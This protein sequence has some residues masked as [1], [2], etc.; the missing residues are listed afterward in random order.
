LSADLPDDPGA[1]KA[2][3]CEQL[4]T[5]RR[6][7]DELRLARHKQSG[8]S[9]ER[10]DPD[11]WQLFNEAEVPVAE[12]ATPESEEI[13]VPAHRRGKGKRQPLDERL[14]RQRIEHDI[15]DA[16]KAGPCGSGGLRVRIG[17]V[18]SEEADIVPAKV[19][20]LQH[21]RFKYGPCRQC[22][23]VFP[24]ERRGGATGYRQ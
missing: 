22:D 24:R 1:L 17:E 21:V 6:L 23:G 4:W 19:K 8:A 9:S 20:I 3:V 18:V 2:L 12:P 16:E 11:Q 5:I 10:S 14:P 15:R 7:E 13:T